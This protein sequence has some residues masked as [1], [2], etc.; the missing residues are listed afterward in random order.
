M[1]DSLS[2]SKLNKIFSDI[3]KIVSDELLWDFKLQK[4]TKKQDFNFLIISD[5]IIIW[6][7][8]PSFFTFCH[9]VN[10]VSEIIFNCFKISVPL[11][12][13]L[14]Y[15]P[16]TLFHKKI[17]TKGV[18]I[19]SSLIGKSIV[20][21]YK[22]SNNLEIVG[23]VITD[24]CYRK[25]RQL[26]QL[27]KKK[28]NHRWDL[29]WYE[30]SMRQNSIFR[31]YIPYKN[32]WKLGYLCDWICNLAEYHTITPKVIFE[33]FT[34]N[35]TYNGESSIAIKMHNTSEYI[36]CFAER[37]PIDNALSKAEKGRKKN[38]KKTEDE[39]AERILKFSQNH[40]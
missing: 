8:K 5:S 28:K 13:A 35:K 9:I 20:E 12:G 37:D 18:H 32:G 30:Q 29:T 21:A 33:A 17:S 14:V 22:L 39:D 36:Y 25:Y 27:E 7:E 10:S 23:C 6:A 16:L 15:G 11:R 34:K 40:D 19:E 2:P 31:T 26:Y 38:I 3:S 1:V 24:N 4:P